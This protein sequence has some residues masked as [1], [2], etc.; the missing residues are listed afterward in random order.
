MTKPSASLAPDIGTRGVVG[1]ERNPD[2]RRHDFS[3]TLRLTSDQHA[4]VKRRARDAGLSL[5]AYIR[6]EL[7]VE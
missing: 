1:R 5:T 3:L 2:G 7:R 4:D 6:R